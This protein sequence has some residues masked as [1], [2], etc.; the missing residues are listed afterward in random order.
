M[1]TRRFCRLHWFA[2]P[3]LLG[4]AACPRSEHDVS[5]Q[6]PAPTSETP[7]WTDV[8]SL[9]DPSKVV[10]IR[11]FSDLPE[12][13]KALANRSYMSEVRDNTPTKFLVGGA[14][15]SSAIVAFE[16]FGYV[17]SFHARAYVFSESRWV[18]AKAWSIDR[19]TTNLRDLLFATS[20]SR[21]RET[22]QFKSPWAS[23]TSQE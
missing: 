5:A 18:A 16:Q 14:S 9:Y 6:S 13:V 12:G 23:P 1:G 11:S 21:N 7:V 2:A 17:P 3:L 19:G 15:E 4:V 10:E 20:S 8:V 22:L